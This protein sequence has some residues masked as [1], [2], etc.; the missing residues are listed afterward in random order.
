[1]QPMNILKSGTKAR[2]FLRLRYLPLFEGLGDM[3]S[4]VFGCFLWRYIFSH[5]PIP[6]SFSALQYSMLRRIVCCCQEDAFALSVVSCG[7][8]LT[9][10]VAYSSYRP[11]AGAK[12]Q[13]DRV[14]G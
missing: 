2:T 9:N 7:C 5:S 13:Q 4:F 3:F 1:M 8:A 14:L 12:R 6:P 11:Q 10:V